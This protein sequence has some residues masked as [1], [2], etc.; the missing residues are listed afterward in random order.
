MKKL[1]HVSSWKVEHGNKEHSV[2]ERGNTC[3]S[4]D[5]QMRDRKRAPPA[6]LRDPQ[7]QEKN[8]ENG[9]GLVFKELVRHVSGS[10]ID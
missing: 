6:L 1:Q 9:K 10:D 5:D 2:T 4:N 8:L 3:L 7:R